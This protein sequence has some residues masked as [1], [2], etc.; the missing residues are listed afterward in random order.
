MDDRLRNDWD[1]VFPGWMID[2]A[3]TW[4]EVVEEPASCCFCDQEVS[5]ERFAIG[6]VVRRA[7][8]RASVEYMFCHVECLRAEMHHAHPLW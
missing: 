1:R 2:D 3:M 8:S 7:F 5:D 4:D 6:L